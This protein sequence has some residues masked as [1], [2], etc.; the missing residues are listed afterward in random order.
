MLQVR[1]RIVH[2]T[3]QPELAGGINPGYRARVKIVPHREEHRH[4]DGE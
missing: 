3:L 1:F 2:V 4:E